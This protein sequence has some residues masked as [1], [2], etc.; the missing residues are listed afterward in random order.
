[1]FSTL[2]PL[3]ALPINTVSFIN[4]ASQQLQNKDV[5][6]TFSSSNK[7]SKLYAFKICNLFYG[8]PV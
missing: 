2:S 3:I 5:F 1:M 8:D 6:F 4:A 7:L